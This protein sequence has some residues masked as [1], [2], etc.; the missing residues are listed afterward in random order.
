MQILNAN[1]TVHMAEII[2]ICSDE[3]SR[4]NLWQARLGKYYYKSQSGKVITK[5]PSIT[6]LVGRY[7]TIETGYE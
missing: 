6:G 3:K 7:C 4:G 5:V 2:F 1:I